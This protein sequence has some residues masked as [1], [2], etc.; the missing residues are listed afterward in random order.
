MTRRGRNIFSGV[1]MRL[2][3][4]LVTGTIRLPRDIGLMLTLI[5]HAENGPFASNF[6]LPLLAAD[7]GRIGLFRDAAP[8]F[9]ARRGPGLYTPSINSRR[10]QG[11]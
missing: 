8:P 2:I 1:S 7:G 10:R 9:I 4:A 11:R 5:A 3:R 6:I